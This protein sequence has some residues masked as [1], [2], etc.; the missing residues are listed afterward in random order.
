MGLFDKAKSFAKS[1]LEE[2][3]ETERK[4]AE[5]Q[6]RNSEISSYT[7]KHEKMKESERLVVDEATKKA[8]EQ[9]KKEFE[10][11]KSVGFVGTLHAIGNQSKAM[12][13]NWDKTENPLALNFGNS[14]MSLNIGKKKKEEGFHI[15]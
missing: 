3:K 10:S 4:R 7:F 14:P 9:A 11:R 8:K 15:F 12:Q 6:R 1:K 2:V 13:K 5:E